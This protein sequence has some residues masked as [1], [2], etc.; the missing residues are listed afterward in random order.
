MKRKLSVLVI[1]L[2]TAFVMNAGAI[3]ADETQY[4]A[5]LEQARQTL[6]DAEAK[7]QL[8]STSEILLADA[9]EAAAAG[10]FDLAVALATEA[11]LQGEL[12]VAT[13]EREKKT[14]Q[15]SVPK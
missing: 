9:E 1:S 6:I 7:V 12:A 14:W 13:A 15:N 4:M 10:D 11:R 3:A 8:W 5:A 2:L